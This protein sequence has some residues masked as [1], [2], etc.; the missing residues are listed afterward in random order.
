MN[1]GDPVYRAN[2]Q[3]AKSAGLKRYMGKPCVYG[4]SGERSVA[5]KSCVECAAR[6][7]RERY[8]SLDEHKRQAELQRMQ[9]YRQNNWPKFLAY[10]KEEHA[11]KRTQTPKWAD[12]K[13]IQ[14]FY[15]ACPP[16]FHVDHVVPLHGRY[17]CGLHVLNNLQYLPAL[18]NLSKGNR[19]VG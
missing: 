4:H 11:R 9:S 19:H 12:R 17:V 7:S 2:Y 6:M 1:W 10:R 15:R 14:K 18:D 3:A 13:A 8:Q 16:G 5:N